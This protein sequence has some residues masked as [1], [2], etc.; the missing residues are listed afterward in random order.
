MLISTRSLDTREDVRA[1]RRHV[2]RLAARLG[3]VPLDQIRIAAAVE[4]VARLATGS[5]APGG[6]AADAEAGTGAAA[7][8]AADAGASAGGR[9]EIAVASDASALSLDISVI[10]PALSHAPLEPPLP[11][12]RH[13]MERIAIATRSERGSGDEATVRMTQR[14]PRTAVPLD[15]AALAALGRELFAD[16]EAGGVEDDELERERDLLEALDALHQRQQELER[17]NVE[18]EDTNRGVVALYAELDD[19]AVHLRRSD[20]MKSAFLSNMSHEFRTPLN[21]ILALTRLLLDGVDGPLGTEQTTQISLIRRAAHD[22][23]ELVNDLLDLAK[24]EAGKITIRPT[25]FEIGGLFGSLRGL[26]R[27]LLSS[28]SVALVFD[29]PAGLPRL[30]TDEAKVA[31]ILRNFISNALKFTEQGEVRVTARLAPREDQVTF[32]VAD[33]GVGIPPQDQER[34]FQEFTQLEHPLQKRVRGTGLGLPLSRKLAEL[35]GGYVTLTSQPGVGSTFALVIPV[36]HPHAPHDEAPEGAAGA[37]PLEGQPAPGGADA[38]RTVL[39]ID[40]EPAARY[41]LRR[42]LE[43]TCAVIEAVN[44]TE[45]IQLAL[46]HRHA[47]IFLDLV[48]PDL[49]GLEV[50][51]ALRADPA[52]RET[53]VVVVSSKTLSPGERA[54]LQSLASGILGKERLTGSDAA[55]I[56]LE[57]LAGATGTKPEGA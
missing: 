30:T 21:S 52:T 12:L 57:A 46:A 29:D 16:D 10:H 45:G 5:E 48:M 22:L 27:P 7:A 49:S 6:D 40:D 28:E 8:R 42:H 50:L 18:L 54:E 24:A 33:T 25:P 20:E 44:G 35:L 23:T 26:L 4:A 39:V 41:V 55:A 53:P 1:A 14:L 2:R 34:I 38:R 31:Q 32:A 37:V 43:G 36:L 9:L 51:R 47:A 11:G 3:F 17:V 13:L 15:A 56:V 19:R